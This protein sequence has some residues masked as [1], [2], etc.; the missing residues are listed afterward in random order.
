ML[1]RTREVLHEQRTTILYGKRN[2]SIKLG[3]G[4]LYVREHQL[5][6]KRILLVIGRHT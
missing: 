3:T 5:L 6:R 2:E 1:G 4:F